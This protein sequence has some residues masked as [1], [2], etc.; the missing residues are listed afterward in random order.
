MN[1]YTF[2]LNP[3]SGSD[4]TKWPTEWVE[5]KADNVHDAYN[6][7]PDIAKMRLAFATTAFDLDGATELTDPEDSPV[8]SKMYLDNPE[9]FTL[10]DLPF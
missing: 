10:E 3:L 1:S 4:V 9:L 8:Y 6:G 7:L 5:V 2:W